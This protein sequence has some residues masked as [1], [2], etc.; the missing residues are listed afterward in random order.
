MPSTTTSK[1]IPYPLTSERV[2][3]LPTIVR[4]S[5]EKL[6]QLITALET[7]IKQLENAKPGSLRLIQKM[8]KIYLN[9]SPGKTS[10]PEFWRFTTPR[11]NT[12][13]IVYLS[14]D[15]PCLQATVKESGKHTDYFSVQVTS[16]SYSV[17]SGTITAL[18]FE[19]VE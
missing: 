19:Y 7:R 2:A 14:V 17:T 8:S 9:I 10:A 4:S 12:N 15:N 16:S 11:E 6:D 5:A 18:V 1:K 13:Y 3:D